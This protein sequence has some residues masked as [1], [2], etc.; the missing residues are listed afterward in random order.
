MQEAL[1]VN[2]LVVILNYRSAELT[3]G[4]LRALAPQVRAMPGVHVVVTDNASGDG[5]LELIGGTIETEGW[6]GWAELM[7]LE[8]NGGFAFGNNAAIRPALE[9]AEPPPPE[10]V[11]LLNPDT[12]PRRGALQELVDFMRAQPSIGIGGSCLEYLDGT[13]HDSRY[14]FPSIWSEIETGL[15]LGIVSRM[16]ARHILAP[17]LVTEAHPIDWVAGASM[18]IRREVFDSVGLFDEGYFLYFEETD[19]CRRARI[20]GWPCW[21]VPASRVVHLVGRSSGL[22]NLLEPA[23]RRP[24]YWFESRRRYFVK[25]HGRLYAWVADVAW[26]VS[27]GLWRIRRRIQGKPDQDPPHLLSDFVRFSFLGQRS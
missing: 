20:A 1:P 11:L 7:P 18:I 2:L 14:R 24:L 16:L 3:I 21:Y 4:C 25:N 15:R 5:S 13:Q 9:R 22:T 12:I 23:R 27:F 6:T 17:A 26:A 19:F 10:F 8:R